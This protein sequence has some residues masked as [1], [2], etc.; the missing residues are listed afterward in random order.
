MAKVLI[1]GGTGLI[2]RQLSKSLADKGYEVIFLSRSKKSHS[3]SP[4]FIW[5]WNKDYIEEGALDQVDY[6]IHLA[7]AN[8]ADKRWSKHRKEQIIHSRVRSA[9]LLFSEIKKK[10]IK[11]KAYI[12]ASAVGYYG[13]ITSDKIFR[14][15]DPA[16]NDFLGRTCADWEVSSDDFKELGIRT[17]KLRT[18]V[19]LSGVG[20]ALAKMSTPIKFGIGSAIGTGK[21]YMPWIHI[22]D[23]CGIYLKAIEDQQMH[24]A[25]NAAAP[26]QLTNAELTRSLAHHLKRLLWLPNIPAF[27]MQLIF[28]KLSDVLLKG[29]R[30][31]SEKLVS[32]GYKFQYPKLD[33]ALINLIV[34]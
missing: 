14:E 21:Q 16:A 5:D 20:G 27:I 1:T 9:Q 8:I 18:A 12:S 6:I 13:A 23:I 3:D 2:G 34:K 22:D 7:G 29:S 28:G 10:D 19:V 32:S 15:T 11:F 33:A 26:E 24:G 17:V 25:Y 31:S 4:I 30:V